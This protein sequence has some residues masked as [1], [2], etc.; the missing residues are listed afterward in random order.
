MK[1]YTVKELAD[2]LQIEQTTV[3]RWIKSGKLKSEKSPE[4]NLSIITEKELNNFLKESP[5]YTSIITAALI[6]GSVVSPIGAIAASISSGVAI[7]LIQQFISNNLNISKDLKEFTKNSIKKKKEECIKKEE[8][9]K[10]S[11]IEYE[12]A[13]TELKKLES[14]LIEIERKEVNEVCC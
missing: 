6:G 13:V 11:K 12:Q 5:K 7:A 14:L 1:N 10:K 2:L 4:K 3:R 9:M 8:I